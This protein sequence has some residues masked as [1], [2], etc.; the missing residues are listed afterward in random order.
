MKFSHAMRTAC[1][2]ALA[3]TTLLAWLPNA[4]IQQAAERRDVAVFRNEPI[5]HLTNENL[6]DMLIDLELSEKIGR[7]EWR[8][9]TLTLEMAVPPDSGRPEAWFRDI[10]KLI[11]ASFVRLDNVQ[12]LLIRIAQIEGSERRL[13]AAVDVRKPDGWLE[14]EIESLRYADPVHDETWRRR[15]RI[16]FTA[17]WEQRFG[18]AAEYRADVSEHH[19]P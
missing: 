5:T 9:G 18:R 12:R 6:I 7:V 2:V 17:A 14:K 1:A 8:N 16:S 15:L 3:A 13:L 19:A 10:Y 4:L 11:E